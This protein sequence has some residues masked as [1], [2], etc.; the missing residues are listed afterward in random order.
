KETRAGTVLQLSLYSELVRTVQGTPPEYFHVVTTDLAKPVKSF[1]VQDFAAYFRFVR[2]RLEA[3]IS[4]GP[5]T[6]AAANY[7]LPVEHCAVCRW[8]STCDRRRRD[9]D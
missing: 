2:E 4:K 6:I 8:W 9:D 7:P 3:T 1:R 5:D